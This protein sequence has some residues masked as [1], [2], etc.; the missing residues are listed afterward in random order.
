MLDLRRPASHVSDLRLSD[1]PGGGGAL[2]DEDQA[3]IARRARSWTFTYATDADR[4]RHAA[5]RAAATYLREH[6]ECFPDDAVPSNATQL[7]VL[8]VEIHIVFL[9][10]DE[11]TDELRI[12]PPTPERAAAAVV[13]A[14]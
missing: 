13:D 14:R 4:V 2:V 7:A 11:A 9:R 10:R 1:L 3:S 12:E 6:P 5:T 8:A